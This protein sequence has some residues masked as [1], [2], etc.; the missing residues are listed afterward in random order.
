MTDVAP[1]RVRFAPSPTGRFHLGSARSAL[2]DFLYAR[3][4]GGKFVLRV[5]DTDRKR[6]DP[7]AE[8]EIIEGL[9][10]LGIEWDE[11]PDVGGPY[12]PYRQS[13]RLDGYRARARE[14]IASE[15]AY[16][17]FCSVER[18]AQVRQAQQRAKQPPHYDGLC[19]R[20]P[21]DEAET[22]AAD[23]E[24]HVVRFK[25]P[26]EGSTTAV[27]LVRGPITVENA[28]IDDYILL[29]SDGMPV[30]H[31]AHLVD[32]HEMAITHVMRG[33]E[34]L[35]TFPLHVMIYQAFGW[36]QPAWVHLSVFLNPSGKGKMSK[37]HA[38]DAKGGAMSIY[39][40]DMRTMG[41]L[42][43]AIDNWIALMG[44]SYDDHTEQ[45]TLE[46]LVERFSLEKLNPSPAAV[47]FSKLEH[48]NGVYL[49]GLAIEDL[50]QRLTP[51]FRAAGLEP[52][53]DRLLAVTPLIQERISTLEEAVEI[54]GF[55]FRSGVSPEP[56]QL[57][58]KDMDAGGSAE[59]ARQARDSISQAETMEPATLE[60][61]LRALADRLDLS[62]GQLFGILRIAVTG[63]PVSPPLIETMHV[64]GK[65]EVVSRIDRA[66]ELLE[67]L[68]PQV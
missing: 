20:I 59:A 24:P 49:R 52:E 12:A 22:R 10:W 13:E 17:C 44:W 16:Y 1:A 39:P 45:F 23:G 33:A 3:K 30:Y 53:P 50:A 27:D 58:G 2:Y 62:A 15:H 63:Q 21:A 66:V 60:P 48:F 38:V 35:P 28:T 40:L 61:R 68:A 11:G 25:T 14:L 55:F 26:S 42:P 34:W 6:F 64:L 32:D 43:E 7:H 65:T 9:H 8:D 37:R 46:E 4:T 57:L 67:G 56:E 5:E 54:A 29:K 51:F 41:Y 19:R 47:N 31:L 18:L 36:E